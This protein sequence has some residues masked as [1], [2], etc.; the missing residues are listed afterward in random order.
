MF[1]QDYKNLLRPF[2][3]RLLLTSAC[4]AGISLA[5]VALLGLSG[6]FLTAA[7]VAGAAGP[8]AVQAFNYLLPS[9]FIRFFAIAR[10]VLRYGERYLGHSA[11]LRVM[12]DLRPALFRRLLGQ[13]RSD[14]MRLSR[15]EAS[16]R[17]VQDVSALENRLVAQSAPAAAGGGLV[18]ALIMCGWATPWSALI[19]LI[20]MATTL[21]IALY[22]HRRPPGAETVSEQAAIGALKTRF[23]ELTAL[24][25]DV[26]AYDLRAPLMMELRDLETRLHAAKTHM[27]GR[28]AITGAVS[29]ILMGL[30][31]TALIASDIHARLADL[32]LSLLAASMAFD[33]LGVLA[34][35]IGQKALFDQA[36]ARVA[37]LYDAPREAEAA[38]LAQ[39]PYLKAGEARYDLDRSLRLRIDGASGGGKTRL[40]EGL[41]G[42][43]EDR[44]EGV[45][46]R[47]LFAL[48]PQDA[49]V[50]TGTVRDNLM[51]AMSDATLKTLTREEQTARLWAALEDAALAE[52][53][54]GMANG[55]ETWIGDGGVTL[56]GGE[57]KRLALARALLRDAPVLILDEPTEGLDLA[58]EAFV[59]D[60]LRDRLKSQGLILISHR[61]APR[62][63]A[64][65]V[66]SV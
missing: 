44:P 20:F 37:D 46:D 9:A 62:I 5:A 41:M 36:Q 22:V 26:R 11:A 25:P 42:L 56:S 57:R 50:L 14:L 53:V 66:L 58:T 19:L 17:F 49:A 40:I 24:L 31:M 28:D 47:A 39:A 48:A 38:V 34:K 6:W 4:A 15:G 29:L 51:M 21:T 18:T 2:G 35:A 63:L 27:V 64:T 8:V 12:A 3:T 65:Q 16:S 55:L 45:Y 60:R 52:R 23:Y 61:E 30:C 13:R 33:S 10:T 54:R 43:R 59:V 32:A 7:A 1:E